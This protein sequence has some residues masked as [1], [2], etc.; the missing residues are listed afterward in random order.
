MSQQWKW[1]SNFCLYYVA[2]MSH[3]A[4]LRFWEV[5]FSG[6]EGKSSSWAGAQG[7]A[8]FMVRR[9]EAHRRQHLPVQKSYCLGSV[10]FLLL[11]S[12]RV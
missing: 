7:N 5:E 12:E 11:G 9:P 6:P 4:L 3:M 10:D 2:G 8:C 1:L